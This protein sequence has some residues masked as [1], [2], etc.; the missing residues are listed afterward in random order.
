MGEEESGGVGK[1]AKV[2]RLQSNQVSHQNPMKEQN[3]GREQGC[4]GGG[5]GH[6]GLFHS[7][8]EETEQQV[9]DERK[10]KLKFEIRECEHKKKRK[11]K[12]NFFFICCR[13]MIIG[14]PLQELEDLF[15][16]SFPLFPVMLLSRHFVLR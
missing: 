12:F 7:W 15:L 16:P 2:S 6:V 14:F 4:G 10:K 11:Q 8:H 3:L 13:L 9:D 5:G 1:P